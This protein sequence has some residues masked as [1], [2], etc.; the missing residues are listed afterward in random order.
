MHNRP[1]SRILS[2]ERT[3]SRMRVLVVLPAIKGVYPADAEQRRVDV[4]RSYTTP[5]LQVDAGFPTQESGYVP[6]SGEGSAV[7]I[8]RNNMMMADRMFQAQVEGYDACVPFGM[9]DFGV[10]TARA[11][12]D[13]P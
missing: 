12:C 13:I 11:R 5:S 1:V 8:G 7:E 6:M 3:Q 4:V 9:R 2:E 10:E